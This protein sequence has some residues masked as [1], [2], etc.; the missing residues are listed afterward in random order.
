MAIFSPILNCFMPLSNSQV[1]NDAGGP[2]GCAKAPSSK[3]SKKSK[4]KS[5][6]SSSRAPII[7]SYFPHN[8]YCSRL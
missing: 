4:S 5:S 3:E 7:V 1:S 6:S 2:K 8:S